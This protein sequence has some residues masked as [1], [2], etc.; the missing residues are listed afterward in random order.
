[1]PPRE[2]LACD[3]VVIRSAQRVGG[4]RRWG[5]EWVR[6]RSRP[7]AVKGRVLTGVEV[8][9][10]DGGRSIADERDPADENWSRRTP[11][12]SAEARV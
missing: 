6:F 7:L 12:A 2:S 3:V 4:G 10:T 1:M 9:E 8:K 5:E 11:P